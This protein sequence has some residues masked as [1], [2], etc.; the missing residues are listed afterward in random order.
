MQSALLTILLRQ[1]AAIDEALVQTSVC[2]APKWLWLLIAW[3]RLQQR[4]CMEHVSLS[5][6]TCTQTCWHLQAMMKSYPGS[7]RQVGMGK[8]VCVRCR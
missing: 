3:R 7:G 1:R 5:V 2:V 4:I 8:G 6:Q